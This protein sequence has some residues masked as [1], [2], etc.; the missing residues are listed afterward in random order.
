MMSYYARIARIL[1]LLAVAALV[2]MAVPKGTSAT[3]VFTVTTTADSGAGSLRDAITMANSN[4]GADTILFDTN[5]FPPD[6][7]ATIHLATN[8][9]EIMG[10][11]GV[12]IDG[13][14]AGVILHG[15]GGNDADGL[16][17]GPFAS[18]ANNITIRNLTLQN[19]KYAIY[20]SVQNVSDVTIDD[21]TINQFTGTS[22]TGINVFGDSTVENVTVQ[23]TT[24]DGTGFYGLDV[25]SLTGTSKIGINNS[26]FLNN[27][28]AGVNVGSSGT[29][30]TVVVSDTTATGNGGDGLTVYGS[31]DI[32]N[33]NI[34][35][36][37]AN[38]NDQ[39]GVSLFSSGNLN[40]LTAQNIEA[41]SN[42]F[43]GFSAGTSAGMTL[44]NTSIT[45]GD[46]W[47]NTQGVSIS[48]GTIN[49]FTIE[50]STA[51]D[52]SYMGIGSAGNGIAF[53][54]LSGGGTGNFIESNEFAGNSAAG[55]SITGDTTV[56]ITGN[57]THDNGGLGID[58]NADGVTLNDAGDVD[59]GPNG[60]LNFPVF[61]GV[62]YNGSSIQGSTPNAITGTGACSGCLID[63]YLADGDPSGY[64]EGE[65]YLGSAFADD[66][67]DFTVAIC[68]F[69]AGASVTGTTRI[70]TGGTSEFSLNYVMPFDSVPC[71]EPQMVIWGDWNCSDAADPVD[72]LLDLRY[73]AGLSTNTG[74]CP[75][76]GTT[77]V[78]TP[79]GGALLWGDLDCSGDAGPIDAL[80]GLRIDAGLSV[81]QG[82]SCPEPKSEIGVIAPPD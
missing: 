76:I 72:A 14:N 69:P 35:G 27:N 33:I 63:L 25:Y 54:S 26:S 46:F 73:D 49:G 10:H 44:S 52:N 61:T 12:S 55:I 53:A 59:T 32:S 64:G 39:A 9:P 68:D 6:S 3:P 57:S 65:T 22:G 8:L 81:S 2:V 4:A 41:K 71:V 51:T 45:G 11:D 30:D 60:L 78:R 48:A 42:G 5:V 43:A 28:S 56:T 36:L 79:E 75:P 23:N 15:I 37:T 7:P 70:P 50:D 40:G 47:G 66:N 20:F 18:D 24:V 13:S 16:T 67:G 74:A 19:M 29:V 34:T 21:V 58:L 77:V 82:D 80:K 62:A 38:E 17:F 31:E 1:P